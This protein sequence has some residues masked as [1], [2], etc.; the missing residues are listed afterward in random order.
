MS[1]TVY[2]TERFAGRQLVVVSGGEMKA[3]TLGSSMTLGR[4]TKGNIVDIPI[5]SDFV[6]RHHATITCT[7]EG[8]FYI[9]NGSMNGTFYNGS[10]LAPNVPVRLLNGDVLHIYNGTPQSCADVVTLIFMLDHPAEFS[11]ETVMLDA[12]TTAINI[13]R[14]VDKDITVFSQ[15]ISGDHA[16]FMRDNNGWAIADHAST[17]GVYLNNRRITA[18]LYL[19]I[20]DCV[21]IV[22]INFV[23][24]GDRIVYQNVRGELL[25]TNKSS[26][27]EI[28]IVQRTVRKL[29]KVHALLRDINV[30]FR[31]GEMILI[32]GGSGAGKTTL[33]NAIL[34][35]EK[36]EGKI[37][38]DNIDLYAD[39]EAVQQKISF[40]PQSDLMR[41]HDSVYYTLRNAAEM[42]LP[43]DIPDEEIEKKVMQTL[44]LFNL[45]KIEDSLVKKLSG[46][47]RK[48][49][50]VAIEY[51]SDPEVFFLDEPDS[52]I[53]GH[54][55]IQLMA[56]LRKIAD[57]GKIIV[58]I[59]H[60]ANRIAKNFDKVLVLAKSKQDMCGYVSFFGTV[61]D[62]Y[63]FFD[64]DNLEAIVGKVNDQPDYFISKFRG[65]YR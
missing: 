15:A 53:D 35:Y 54:Y 2:Y 21:R 10:A 34:G 7:N 64:T 59:S 5:D 25:G 20:G 37:L 1:N 48:R 45:D 17:N 4:P 33:V 41:D 14:S 40:V 63:A 8:C 22:N 52:G 12:M 61:E 62:S 31:S 46:G 50:S 42:K 26:T 16:S 23:F 28:H 36:A 55:T 39:D 24:L 6:S 38:Y 19:R 60:G 27:L 51:I 56:I 65:L 58:I 30:T 13:G 43:D 9:D 18:P 47:E 57:E 32:L 11:G 49:L 44:K 3:V 29:F